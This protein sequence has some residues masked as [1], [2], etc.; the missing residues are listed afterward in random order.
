MAEGSGLF[1]SMSTGQDGGGS[2]REG[3]GENL[4]GQHHSTVLFVQFMRKEGSSTFKSLSF[5]G[6]G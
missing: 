2:D 5:W 4:V 1:S 6:V 3:A